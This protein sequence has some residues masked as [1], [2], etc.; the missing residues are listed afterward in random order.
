MLAAVLSGFAGVYFERILKG[1][2]TSLWM[3]NVQMGL[4]TIPLAI[5]GVT[6]SGVSEKKTSF[7]ILH[8]L[9]F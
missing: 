9:Y 3:R 4:S 8:P 7:I 1:S 2:Q 6:L 5:F